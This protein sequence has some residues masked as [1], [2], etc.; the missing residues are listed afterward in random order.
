MKVTTESGFKCEIDV[1]A[2]NDWELYEILLSGDDKLAETRFIKGV[3]DK[4]MSREDAQR[5][6]DH[7]RTESGRIP[8]NAIT[9]EM[10]EIMQM[11]QK[12]KNS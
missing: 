11:V 7:V 12:E 2:L 8:A 9:N 1:E 3:M 4:C 6:K 5:L 10:L